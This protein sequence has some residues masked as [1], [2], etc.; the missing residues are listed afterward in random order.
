[1]PPVAPDRTISIHSPL[2]GRDARRWRWTWAGHNFNPLAPRG[3]RRYAVGHSDYQREISIHLP[4]AGRDITVQSSHP[5]TILFQSTRPSRGETGS[6]SPCRHIG[7]FQSTRPSR[8]E[9]SAPAP[10]GNSP[11]GI[12]PD[13]RDSAGRGSLCRIW[14]GYRPAACCRIPS[15][16]HP[17]F[18]D[19]PAPA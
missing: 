17:A 8:G 3:V 15:G 7:G 5:S 14:T 13:H 9:T 16:R 19:A 18:S 11:T 10:D 4:L 6:A 12:C 1:M 2:V